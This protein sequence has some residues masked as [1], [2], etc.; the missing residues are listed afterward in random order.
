[1]DEYSI[2]V[3]IEAGSPA[4]KLRDF[5]WLR[6]LKNPGLSAMHHAVHDSALHIIAN[7]MY[8]PTVGFLHQ[9]GI[10]M[11][12][13]LICHKQEKVVPSSRGLELF[14]NVI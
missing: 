14:N 1:M 6:Q 3:K 7:K 12:F 5:A 8:F 13:S 11:I 4:R 10:N 9:Q 2:V